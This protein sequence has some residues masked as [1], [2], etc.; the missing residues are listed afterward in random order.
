MPDEYVQ[1]VHDA[2]NILAAEWG[3]VTAVMD[4]LVALEAIDQMIAESWM[5]DETRAA[6]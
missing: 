2:P 3:S 1:G 4:Q 5:E 6:S